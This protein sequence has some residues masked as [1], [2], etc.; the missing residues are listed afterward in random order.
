MVTDY[1]QLIGQ[2]IDALISLGQAISTFTIHLVEDSGLP[3]PAQLVQFLVTGM[4]LIF[5]I[6]SL[7]RKAKWILVFGGILFVAFLMNVLG[8][9]S[10][11]KTS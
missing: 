7:T 3:V 1:T 11:F 6:L 9:L 2:I 8:L 4:L 5:S 10:Y